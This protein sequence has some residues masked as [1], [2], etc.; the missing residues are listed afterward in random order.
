MSTTPVTLLQ[1]LMAEYEK[2]LDSYNV[3]LPASTNR[4]RKNALQQFEEFA[5]RTLAKPEL[6]V[7]ACTVQPDQPPALQL[8]NGQL[9]PL[10][11]PGPTVS[12]VAVFPITGLGS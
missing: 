4:S 9:L 12:R 6:R 1:Y 5:H 10:Y 8:A 7:T 3:P 2:E 11:P